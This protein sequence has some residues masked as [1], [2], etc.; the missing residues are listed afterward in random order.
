M[1]REVDE[2]IG[3]Q[4]EVE[5]EQGKLKEV[6]RQLKENNERASKDDG[7]RNDQQHQIKTIHQIKLILKHHY[8]LVGKVAL[9]LKNLQ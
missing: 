4:S 9:I 7:D 3:V 5:G 6:Q 1:E 8:H 2:V